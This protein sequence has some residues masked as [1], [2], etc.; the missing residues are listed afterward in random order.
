MIEETDSEKPEEIID[1]IVEELD[2]RHNALA[3]ETVRIGHLR[4]S[5]RDVR[6]VWKQ[7]G[8]IGRNNPDT[9]PIYISAVNSLTAFREQLRITYNPFN[10][11]IDQIITS[12]G[13]AGSVL[14]GT[15]STQSFYPEILRIPTKPI[16][17]VTS[18]DQRK[19]YADRFT[20][21]DPELGKTYEGIWETLYGTRADPQRAALYLMRQAYDHLF[22]KLSPDN[23]VRAS[24]N[25]SEKPKER[26][27]KITRE[28]RIFFAA[29]KHI[30]N[31][32]RRKTLLE[33][34]NH[35]LQVYRGLNRAHKRGELDQ[36]KARS[37]LEEMRKILEDWADAI[38]I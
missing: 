18:L 32:T 38:D 36:N 24:P 14:F 23:E 25:W 26:Q 16:N 8:R 10:E 12:V 11:S 13:S 34:A 28:E 22:D 17:L 20:R 27:D 7:L 31:D 5:F 35:M 19:A 33:S 37:A 6:P 2:A 3:D 4:D 29:N 15:K 9:E 30:H 21:F 1:E